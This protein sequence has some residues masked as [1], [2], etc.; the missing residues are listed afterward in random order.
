MTETL[1]TFVAIELP[2]QLTVRLGHLQDQLRGHRFNIRWVRP[3]NIHLTLKFLGDTPAAGLAALGDALAAAAR[4]HPSFSLFLKGFGAFPG[5]DRPRVVWVGID[6]QTAALQALQRAIEGGLASIGF[7]FDNRPFRGHLTLGR[8]RGRV[9]TERLRNAAE[10]L[11]AFT[12][13]YF[14]VERINLFRSELKPTG[15]VYTRL[16]AVD[17]DPGGPP[18]KA[19]GEAP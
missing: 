7:P 9:E 2:R 13:E 16:R 18:A 14:A 3:E 6:G 17:L 4:G 11:Q 8:I 10:A 15:A 5:L 12:S 19:R 1:R